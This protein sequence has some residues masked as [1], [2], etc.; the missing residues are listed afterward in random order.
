MQISYGLDSNKPTH[1]VEQ[2]GTTSI[3]VLAANP[4]RRYALL[5]NDGT[6]VIYIKLGATAVKNE[7][8]RINANGGCYEI[9]PA[10]NNLYHGAIYAVSNS[11]SND[12][13]ITECV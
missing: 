3:S 10:K 11:N 6:E 12:L 2:V 4:K 1:T 5:I 8:I 7:G 9:S 13:L